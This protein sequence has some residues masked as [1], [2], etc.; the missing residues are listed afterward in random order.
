[1]TRRPMRHK[2]WEYL[3][4]VFYCSI[5]LELA[6]FAKKSHEDFGCGPGEINCKIVPCTTLA[7]PASTR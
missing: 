7:A 3:F 4:L 6:L 5:S 1:M 2:P